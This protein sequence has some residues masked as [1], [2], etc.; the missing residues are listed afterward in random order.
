MT[1]KRLKSLFLAGKNRA[2]HLV[3]ISAFK[4]ESAAHAVLSPGF[5]ISGMIF[6][7]QVV[8]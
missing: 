6:L 4:G 1:G 3:G 2:G 5:K 8:A 7:G